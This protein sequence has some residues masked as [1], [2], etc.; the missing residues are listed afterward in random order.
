MS[1]GYDI[2]LKRNIIITPQ[3]SIASHNGMCS[4]NRTTGY[5][6]WKRHNQSSQRPKEL[7]YGEKRKEMGNK[8]YRLNYEFNDSFY[9]IG[10]LTNQ[11]F[12]DDPSDQALPLLSLFHGCALTKCYE[13]RYPINTHYV[14]CIVN[15]RYNLTWCLARHFSW[16]F[17][18]VEMPQRVY[19]QYLY[20]VE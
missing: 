7:C 11:T 5:E 6:H 10:M 4:T 3:L 20:L 2:T 18:V 16:L 19:S 17:R 13:D 14:C 12:L 9:K 1:K 15:K 8:I